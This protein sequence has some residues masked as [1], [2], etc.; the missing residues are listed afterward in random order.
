MNPHVEEWRQGTEIMEWGKA[1]S[2]RTLGLA[3]MKK[4]ALKWDRSQGWHFW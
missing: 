1:N 4:K 3:Q 2:N